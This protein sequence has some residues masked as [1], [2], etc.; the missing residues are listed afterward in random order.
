[1]IRAETGTRPLM[2]QIIKRYISYIQSLKKNTSSFAH[3]A[4]V[5]ET[6]NHDPN[7]DN[8]SFFNFLEKFN[9]DQNIVNEP[10]SKIKKICNDTYDRL[11]KNEIN[12]PNSKAISYCEYKNTIHLEPYLYQ[13]LNQKNRVSIS[14]FRLSNH[15][16]MIE[17]GRHAKPVKIKREERFCN[18]CTK[19]VEDEKHFLMSCPLYTKE[20]QKL[21]NVCTTNCTLYSSMNIDQKFVF[22]LSNE[23]PFIIKHLGKFITESMT[24]REKLVEYFFT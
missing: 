6:K 13:R 5:Y 10:K 1:M 16:L 14:R 24:L 4:L 7:C 19:M 3:S 8:N 20:R 15:S 9:L 21:E 11:W 22:I 17:K 23:N 2:N 12:N 18:F